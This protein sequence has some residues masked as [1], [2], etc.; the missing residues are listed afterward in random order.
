MLK[1]RIMPTL[2]FK[3][4]GLVKGIGFDSW[5]RVGSVMQ[6]VKVYNLREV[7][8]L[9]FVDISATRDGRTPDLE[10]VDTIADECFMPL[11]VG[12]GVRT[13]EDFRNLLRVGA[14]KVAVNT[15]AVLNPSLIAEA[16]RTFG[17][18]C[19]V[20]SIDARRRPGGGHE[21][22]THAGTQPTGLDVVDFAREVERRGAGEIL[23]TS[24]ERDGTMSGYDLELVSSVSAAVGIGVIA[25]GGAGRY[26]HMAEAI[27]RGRASAVAAAAIFH[28]T[29]Q[30]PLEAKRHL[31]ERGI[32]V[33]L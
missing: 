15:A 31:K 19:V 32:P 7:D 25:S 14:D 21:V 10:T 16:A 29:E 13:I 9:V 24:I 1:T 18:Q 17:E 27:L 26:H 8:E 4:L 23:L 2:L 12:G 28:Y 5:R 22:F 3:D 6:A 33:R 20:V 11:T 30:T